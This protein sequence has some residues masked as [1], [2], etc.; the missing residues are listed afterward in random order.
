MRKGVVRFV[1]LDRS[2]Q[3]VGVGE[4]VH[5]EPDRH[6][7][8]HLHIDNLAACGVKTVA[9]QVTGRVHDDVACVTRPTT[10][11][12]VLVVPALEHNRC[13]RCAVTM[14]GND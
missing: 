10:I 7:H 4:A 13:I 3:E 11:G 8:W 9:M 2:K 14:H 1:T 5:A 6:G 12:A